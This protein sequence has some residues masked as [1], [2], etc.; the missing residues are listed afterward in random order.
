LST[1]RDEVS[2]IIGT[3][4]HIDHGKTALIKTLTGIETDRL[5]EERE[6]GIS[7]DLGFAHFDTDD[8]ERAGVVDVPGHERFIRNMLA[9][10]HGVDL[11]LLVVAAD[12]G[13]MPQTEEHLDILHLL[14]VRH[15]IVVVTKIDLVDA[16]RIAAVHEEIAILLD[17]TTLEGAPICDVSA[18]TGAGMADLAARIRVQARTANR[19]QPVGYFRLP[20]DRAFSMHGHGLVVTGTAVG[21][22]IEADAAVRILPGDHTARV[23]SIQV[24]GETVASAHRGQRIALNLSGVDRAAVTRG[25]VVC[26]AELQLATERFD[27]RVEI[28]PG[29]RRPIAN[30][31]AVRVHLGTAEVL[32]KVVWLDGRG[33]MAPKEEGYAQVVLREPIVACGGDRFVLRDQTAQRTIGG[34]VVLHPFAVRARRRSDER[35]AALACIDRSRSLSERLRAL[36]NLE[37]AFAVPP[38][39]LAATANVTVDDVRC[40]LAAERQVLPLPEPTQP[41]AYTTADKWRDLRAAVARTLRDFHASQP[42]QRGMEMESLRSHVVPATGAKVFRAVLLQLEREAA[43]VREESVVRLPDHQISVDSVEQRVGEQIVAR[44]D[45]AGFAPPDVAELARALAIPPSRLADYAVRLERDGALVRASADLWFG[46]RAVEA[47]RELIRQHTAAHGAIDAAAFRDLMGTSR[48]FSIA[49]L[50]YFDRTGFTL[51]VGDI[52]R[53]RQR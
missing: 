50:T 38:E 25:H 17:G 42:R 36:L 15:G 47:A 34:G 21:G 39:R 7:I 19:A 9:G 44:L 51:R 22:R 29:A 46:A 2:I 24:H 5:K 16:A 52:R 3:A 32:A 33:R 40:A 4:G 45:A 53:L 18:I 1:E 31:A 13:V 23:R 14:G 11:V 41:D 49:L 28:R 12:D 30:H 48:K 8:G 37:A 10:A 35:V 6:R 27:A 20:V 43:L 26:A